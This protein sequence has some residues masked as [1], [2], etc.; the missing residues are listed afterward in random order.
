MEDRD[1]QQSNAMKTMKSAMAERE[2]ILE[3]FDPI[4]AKGFTQIP[5]AIL[6]DGNLNDGD[7]ITYALLLGYGWDTNSCFPGQETLATRQGKTDRSIRTHLK[8]LEAV[9]WIT[10]NQRGF[11]KTNQYTLHA[12]VLKGGVRGG[13]R[14]GK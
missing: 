3:G 4:S 5:N 1:N 10:I 14:K 2:I 11:N 7:K 6:E 12:R 9:G 8:N 13:A